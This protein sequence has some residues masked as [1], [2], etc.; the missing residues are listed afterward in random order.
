MISRTQSKL[1]T[2]ASEIK[3]A[4]KVQ[5]ETLAMDFSANN[6]S[7]YDR[8]SSLIT[9]KDISILINNV[10]QSHSIP[11]LFNETE[12]TEINNII[13]INCFG[14][15]KITKLVLPGMLERKRGLILTMGSF[16]GQLPTPY[17]ATYSGSKAFLQQWSTALASEVASSGVYVHF[18][19]SYL[20]TSA[21]SKVRRPTMLIPAPKPF[22]KTTLNKIGNTG[23]SSHYAYSGTP[24]WS[25]GLGMWIILTTVGAYSNIAL[26]INHSLHLGIRKAALRKRDRD[27]KKLEADGGKKVA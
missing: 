5:V 19:H 2:L 3:S 7:D 22:V 4:N 10:G 18:V 11:V 26:A 21:M 14:T 9:G 20:V 16:G 8:V 25:H 1:D 27:R 24:W 23:G 17:L 12:A 6:P 15:L 13:N